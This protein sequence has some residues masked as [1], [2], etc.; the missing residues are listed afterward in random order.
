MPSRCRCRLKPCSTS[1]VSRPMA[2]AAASQASPVDG[3]R[4]MKSFTFAPVQQLGRALMLPI[5]VLP[6][7]GLLLRLGQDDLL[8]IAFI[9][10]AGNAIFANLGLLFAIGIAVGFADENHGAAGLAGAVGFLVATNGAEALVAIP[11]D[12]VGELAIAGFKA[13]TLATI[14]VPCGIL[15]GIIAGTLY[16]RFKDI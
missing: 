16:N 6:V 8:G 13:K 14:S 5:A 10:A 4:S 11:P 2:A 15:S 12:V 3:S 1:R 9:A 7:A